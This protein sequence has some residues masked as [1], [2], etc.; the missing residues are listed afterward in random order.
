MD[1]GHRRE[2]ETITSRLAGRSALKQDPI[3]PNPSRTTPELRIGLLGGTFDPPHH[4]HLIL[5]GEALACAGLAEVWLVPAWRSPLR[6]QDAVTPAEVRL[7]LARLAAAGAEHIGVAAIEVEAGRQVFTV[8]TVERLRRLHPGVAFSWILGAD[9]FAQLD[10]WR[11]VER[12]AEMVDFLVAVRGG[13]ELV[14]PAPIP[15]LRFRRLSMGRVDISSSLIRTRI[16][17][18]LPWAH[19][20]PPAVAA[21]VRRLDLYPVDSVG[22]GIDCTGET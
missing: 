10:R 9:Q 4:G 17:G 8:E 14:A 3:M 1:T 2:D 12:L 15:G 11:E 6:V 21:E 5:A 13:E 22:D 20:V 7:H 19:F 16:A 18:G